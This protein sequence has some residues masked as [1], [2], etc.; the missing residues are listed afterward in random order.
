MKTPRPV[1]ASGRGKANGKQA[2]AIMG[3]CT[4]TSKASAEPSA[5]VRSAK[6]P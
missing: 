1:E 6:S 3:T 4:E 2:K 5:K